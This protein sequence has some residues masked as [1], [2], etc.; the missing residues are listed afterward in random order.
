MNTNVRSEKKNT[1]P[2]NN[3]L[4]GLVFFFS[5]LTLLEIV[6]L[7]VLASWFETLQKEPFLFSITE[8]L[9]DESLFKQIHQNYDTFLKQKVN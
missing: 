1:K 8:N 7:N 4:L 9:V 2:S 3:T 5:E 6:S